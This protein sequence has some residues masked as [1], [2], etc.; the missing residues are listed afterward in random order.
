LEKEQKEKED[1]KKELDVRQKTKEEKHNAAGS[2]IKERMKT[3]YHLAMEIWNT[4]ISASLT[5]E[6]GNDQQWEV[7]FFGGW[8]CSTCKKDP[9]RPTQPCSPFSSEESRKQFN[10]LI[11]KAYDELKAAEEA[12][13]PAAE[14]KQLMSESALSDLARLALGIAE[15]HTSNHKGPVA[16]VIMQHLIQ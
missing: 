1:L 7:Y 3:A 4:E 5:G 2:V 10:Y 15:K 11:I 16:A 13:K 12:E 9:K 8:R 14:K 6:P